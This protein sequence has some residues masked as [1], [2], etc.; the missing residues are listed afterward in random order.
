MT[1]PDLHLR[2]RLSAIDPMNPAKNPEALGDERAARILQRTMDT[3]DDAPLR[4]PLRPRLALR[5]RR[6]AV[7]AAAAVL[8]LAA[9]VGTV[10]VVADSAGGPGR[11]STLRLSAGSADT[12][13]SC[14][15]FD[16]AILREMPVAFAGTV[17]TITADAVTLDVD[18]WYKGGEADLVSIDLPDGQSSVALDG[19][20]FTSGSGYLVTATNGVVNGCGFSGEATPELEAAYAEA[21]L[22]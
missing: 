18:R 16:V 14:V 11:A 10:L 9:G 1:D 21:F 2:I 7:L 4:S 5:R 8:V 13:A 12:L 17:T 6:F 3:A 15:G 22:G 20:E 19:V